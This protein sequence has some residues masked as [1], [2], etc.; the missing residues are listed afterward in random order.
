MRADDLGDGRLVRIAAPEGVEE[1]GAP[2]D[3]ELEVPGSPADPPGQLRGDAPAELLEAIR[4][5]IPRRQDGRAET[6]D[7][8]VFVAGDGANVMGGDDPG[9]GQALDI[10]QDEH[11][12]KA[13]G[14]I[15]GQAD[16][17]ALEGRQ[18][19]LEP[20]ADDRGGQAVA[21]GRGPDRQAGDRPEVRGPI[22]RPVGQVG[23]EDRGVGAH[24]P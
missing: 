9:R 15:V 14:L 7:V 13:R 2:V 8:A 6:L 12:P 21:D 18:D 19:V 10:A 1:S 20:L 3:L 4:A 16:R 11:D 17:W 22:G 23:D 24:R 5:G